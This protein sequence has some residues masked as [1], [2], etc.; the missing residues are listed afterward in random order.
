MS[1]ECKIQAVFIKKWQVLSIL[2]I[3]K[4]MINTLLVV[5]IKIYF[6]FTFDKHFN[7]HLMHHII[8]TTTYEA[9]ILIQFS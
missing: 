8:L 7:K 4:I 5:V 6:A 3:I 1:V 2:Q 9:D